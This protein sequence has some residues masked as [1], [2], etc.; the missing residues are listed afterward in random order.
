N[1]D[2]YNYTDLEY[3]TTYYWK[4]VE[5][6]GYPTYTEG[7]VW[8][9]TTAEETSIENNVAYVTTLNQNYPNP[10][11]PTTTI[12]FYN[13]QKGQ[14]KLTVYNMKGELVNTLINENIS[15]GFK[16]V[17]FDA[18]ALNSGVYYYKLETSNNT[19]TKKMLLIK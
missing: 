10:F 8:S 4:V 12:G 9:F 5:N 16:S 7:Y 15:K 2:S 6:V 14:V 3:E 19:S 18:T 11:N 13:N 17:D 1:I